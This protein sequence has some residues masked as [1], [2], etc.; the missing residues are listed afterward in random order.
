MRRLVLAVAA[1]ASLAGCKVE[2]TVEVDADADGTGRVVAEVV[3]DDDAVRR[4]PGLAEQLRVDDLRAAGWQVEKP[5]KAA[6]GGLVVEAAKRF[7]TP[8]EA[9][10]AVEELT[11]PAGPFRGFELRRERSFLRTRTAFSGTVDLGRGIEAFGDDVLRDRLGGSSLGLDPAELE[12]RLG[13]ALSD[14][15]SFRVVARLP[16]NVSSDASGVEGDG[17]VWRPAL[18]ETVVVHATSVRWNVRSIAAAA[19]SAVAAAALAIVLARRRRT[20]RSA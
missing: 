6:A 16:G 13:T 7:R 5:R 15:F 12:S 14:V 4:V 8:A 19:V 18:G 9:A 11:G 2:T 17:V 1:L 20:G 10:Q 3:L